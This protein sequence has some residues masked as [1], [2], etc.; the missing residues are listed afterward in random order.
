MRRTAFP[1]PATWDRSG[2]EAIGFDGFVQLEEMELGD[3]PQEHGVYVV[4]RPYTDRPYTFRADSPLRAYT[5]EELEKRWVAG[6]P[7]VYIGKAGSVKGLRERL[8]P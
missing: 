6:A 3:V 7:I 4:L 8:R 1:L 2:L 5:V